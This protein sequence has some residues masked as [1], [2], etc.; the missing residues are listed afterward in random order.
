MPVNS[1]SIEDAIRR[2]EADVK[3]LITTVNDEVVPQV[4]K[5]SG[6]AIRLASEALAKLAESLEKNRDPQP[7]R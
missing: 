5:E 7:P 6:K 4:R 3:R 2:V 1:S